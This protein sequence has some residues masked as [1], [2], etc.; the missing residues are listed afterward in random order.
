MLYNDDILIDAVMAAQDV[1]RAEAEQYVPLGCGEIVLDH[2]SFGT[3]SGAINLLKLLEVTLHNGIDPVTGQVVGLQTGEF[4]SFASFEALFAAYQQQATYFIE[5]LAD[6]EAL[7]YQITGESTPFLYLSMLYDDCLERGKGLFAG[8]I[9]YLGG[10]LE[11][12]GNVNTADS[13]TAIKELVFDRRV[14]TPE[15][16]LEALNAN[17]DGSRRNGAGCSTAPNSATTTP[18]PITCCC[19]SITSSAA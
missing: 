8:G 4:A 9:R 11:T 12:Y 5:A 18:T 17:F 6:H 2:R 19:L 14:I 10:T 15:R 1:P 7:E 13:L 16:L 3:P